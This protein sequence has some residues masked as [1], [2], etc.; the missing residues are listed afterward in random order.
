MGEGAEGAEQIQAIADEVAAAQAEALTRVSAAADTEALEEIRLHYLGRRGVLGLILRGLGR[1]PA[2]LRPEAG[3]IANAARTAV[4]AAIGQRTEMLADRE[5]Q[6]RW[7]AE[8]IDVTMPGRPVD[9]GRRHPLW[10]VLEQIEDIFLSMGYEIAQGPEVEF[11]YYNFEA[12]NY[13]P[14]HPAR[15]MQDSFY[16]NDKVL[17]RTHTSPVQIRYMQAK[18]PNLPV[19]I[20]APGRVFRRDDDATHSPMFHQIEGLLVDRQVSLADLKGTLLTFVRRLFGSDTRIRLRPSYFPFTEPSAELDATCPLCHGD[21]CRTCGHSGWL[22]LLGCGM[23]HPNVL[24]NGG[25]D[26]EHVSGFA[27]GMGLERITMVKFGIDDLRLLFQNNLRFL[28]QLD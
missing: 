10:I 21:G 8:A 1:L 17:L 28:R 18:A 11:D 4:A 3:G 27:F 9:H 14:D 12:L 13:P 20:I 23:V 25:Y 6:L 22:E 16:I 19:R 24:R 15:D 2:P 26:P 5:R 7:Q